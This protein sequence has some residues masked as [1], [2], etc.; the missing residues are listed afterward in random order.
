MRFVVGP[1]APHLDPELEEDAR[2]EQALELLARFRADPLQ[3]LAA[4]RR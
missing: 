3:P 2:V 1:A 4:G